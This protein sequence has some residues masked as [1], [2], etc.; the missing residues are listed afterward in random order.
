MESIDRLREWRLG[1]F[2]VM[3]ARLGREFRDL[4][5]A[6]EQ[7]HKQTLHDAVGK[8]HADGERNA[9]RQV[10]NA[11]EDYR[12]GYDDGYDAGFASAD[13]WAAQHED[14]MAEHGWVRLPVDAEGEPI[15]L[16]DY[17]E[18]DEYG[19]KQ[20]PCRG[21]NVEVCTSGKRW[22]VCMSYDSYSGT[23]EYTPANRCHHVKPPTVEDVL[24]EF[25]EKMNENLGMYT[26]EAIDAD[27]WRDA[28][29]KTIA[30]FAAKL[31]LRGDE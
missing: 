19:G 8:A 24:R 27:E 16:G 9:L 31:T 23:S 2:P 12:R 7:E 15:H 22:T 28:D 3:D 29:A 11:I 5:D 4:L 26:G 18:S 14:A 6:I 13:D 21:L 17:L 20:F 10:R 1:R 30:E 25:A